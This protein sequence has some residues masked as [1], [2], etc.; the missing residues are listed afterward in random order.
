MLGTTVVEQKIFQPVTGG[1]QTWVTGSTGKHSTIRC[2][3]SGLLTFFK[4]FFQ[5]HNQS[6][7]LYGSDLGLGLGSKLFAEDNCCHR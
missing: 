3:N 4:K 5:E 1:N 7:K 2:K 6:V